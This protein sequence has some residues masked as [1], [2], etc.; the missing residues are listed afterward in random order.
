[1]VANF[2]F[3]GGT[4]EPF[5]IREGV[6]G[7]YINGIVANQ[8]AQ[9]LIDGANSETVQ[10]GALTDKI[11]FHSVFFDS[12]LAGQTPAVNTNLDSSLLTSDSAFTVAALATSLNS[13]KTNLTVGTNTLVDTYF[14]GTAESAVPSA[15]S[16][17]T[18]NAMCE[19]GTHDKA[20]GAA[21][22]SGL[23]SAGEDVSK[24]GEAANYTYTID[25]FFNATDYIGAFAPGSDAEN[26]WAAGWTIGLF[27][28]PAC[29][30]GTFESEI[31]LGRKVCDLNGVITD[32]LTLVAGNYYKLDGKVEVGVDAGADPSNP[33]ANADTAILTVNPGVTIFGLSG[34]DYLVINRGSKINAVGTRSAPIVMTGK[35]E[36]LG[37]ADVDRT[38]GL[39]G[40]LIILGQA[41]INKCTYTGSVKANP[42]EK[43]VEGTVGNTMG[44]EVIDDSSGA[45]KYLR[46]QYAGYE[47]FSGNELNGITFGGVGNGTSVEYVQVH[48]NVDDCVEF[49]GGTVDV[50]HL[51]CTGAGDDNLDIDWGY[52]GRLQYVI[53]QQASDA[54]D[55]I[56]ES[57][58]T[59]SD[60]NVG[61]LTEPRSNPIVS[62]FT[63]ISRG[64]DEI[65]KLKEGVSG[66]YYNGVAAVLNAATPTLT[67]GCIETTFTETTIKD[68]ASTPNF[69]MNSVAFDCPD[70][71]TSEGNSTP[72]LVKIGEDSTGVHAATI[73]QVEAIVK[74]GTNNLYA[75]TSGGGSYA[76]TLSGV[77]NGSNESNATA[78]PVPAGDNVDGFFNVPSTTAQP[79]YIG[80]V[81]DSTDD[82][83][84][85]WTLP[86]SIKL[87]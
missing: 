31:L 74:A 69:S 38:R 40:G 15:F 17:G 53:V 33:A 12:A 60:G 21:P 81:K 11:A 80:A 87:N 51:I 37:L 71:D 6:S 57:D 25:Q 68:G 5:K 85:V 79:T 42:C 18:K 83:Y 4:D 76:N 55:H 70:A 29:P 7:I 50:K 78:T 66:Q 1:M 54:G 28:D 10:D 44:G 14:L 22:K 26:N 45:L 13:R 27:T 86:G 41:P 49:F 58:N 39:W 20:N 35:Q 19:V 8:Q 52:Q 48:N 65:F 24:E 3:I 47:V 34:N 73:A 84:K 46:V 62:N 61:Y 56:V 77:V 63:F 82:W 64:H 2:T 9:K 16:V 23:C 32:D 30:T 43:T 75:A 36:I 67:K 59:N 72:D